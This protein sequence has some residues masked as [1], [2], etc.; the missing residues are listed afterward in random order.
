[1]L[2]GLELDQG[3]ALVEV[4]ARSIRASGPV[5][6]IR[7]LVDRARRG[8]LHNLH[9]THDY[10]QD[11]LLV[12]AQLVLGRHVRHW[13]SPLVHPPTDRDEIRSALLRREQQLIDRWNLRSLGWNRG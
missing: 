4:V 1:M 9:P 11:G 10:E 2:E 3:P 7:R 12:G 8:V 6:V 13:V 5:G